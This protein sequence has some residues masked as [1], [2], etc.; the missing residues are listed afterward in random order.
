MKKLFSS[1]NKFETSFNPETHYAVMR[2]SICTGEKTVGFRDKKTGVF[3]EVMLIRS[4]KDLEKF[5]EMYN[6]E[7]IKTEY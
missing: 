3:S 5:K 4:Q 2:S 6:I 7:N 1:K